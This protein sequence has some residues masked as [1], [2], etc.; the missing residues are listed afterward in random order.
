[1]LIENY[2]KNKRKVFVD[3]SLDQLLYDSWENKFVLLKETTK[4]HK[5]D[6]YLHKW[7]TYLS[8][9]FGI[10]DWETLIS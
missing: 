8:K 7:K 2:Q 3:I 10:V 1:M 6:G 9:D 5:N 4:S